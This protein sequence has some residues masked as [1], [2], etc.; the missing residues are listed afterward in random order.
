MIVLKHIIILTIEFDNYIS[1]KYKDR[2]FFRPR[3]SPKKA[4]NRH[5]RQHVYIWLHHE[6][7]QL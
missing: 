6:H 1:Q 2:S 3:H 4:R 5:E 7:V